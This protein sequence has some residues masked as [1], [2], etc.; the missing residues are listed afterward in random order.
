MRDNRVSK[1]AFRFNL[2]RCDVVRSRFWSTLSAEHFTDEELA[3]R[4][5]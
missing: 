2:C 3:V 4:V 1:F 5:A